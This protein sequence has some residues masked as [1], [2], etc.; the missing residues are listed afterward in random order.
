MGDGRKITSLIYRKRGSFSS[1]ARGSHFSNTA[2][3]QDYSREVKPS[4]KSVIVLGKEEWQLEESDRGERGVST[5]LK[6]SGLV[7]LHP[8]Y[9]QILD[10]VR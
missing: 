1:P 8:P 10:Q 4:G 2:P 9:P 7:F 5:G 6:I 3:S